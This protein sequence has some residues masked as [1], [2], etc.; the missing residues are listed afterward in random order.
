MAGLRECGRPSPSSST[1]RVA[2]RRA[3]PTGRSAR[4]SSSYG[5]DDNSNNYN[6][7]FSVAYVSGTHSFKVGFQTVQ[8]NYDFF[9]M[10]GGVEQVNYQFRGGV[11]VGIVQVAG[12]F[13]SLTRLSG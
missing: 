5:E 6:Q 12:P 4:A 1:F 11:P 10:Q 13:Q 3:T 9:G 7:R 2:R 8:G